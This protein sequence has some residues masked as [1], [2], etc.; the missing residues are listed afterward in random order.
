MEGKEALMRA[1]G[2]CALAER[3]AFDVLRKLKA[4]GVEEECHDDILDELFREHYLDHGRYAC[5]F[6]RDKHRFSG[7]GWRRIE[8]ELRLRQ[9]TSADIAC[10]QQMLAEQEQEGDKLN[11]V[12]ERKL[13]SFPPSLEPRKVY[14]R[15]VRFGLYRGYDYEAVVRTARQLLNSDL[16]H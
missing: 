3:C 8:Q 6:A 14:E 7:W 12:L 10:A 4:W 16:E 13:R 2:Y 11:E 5:A 9:I 15:L 1:M